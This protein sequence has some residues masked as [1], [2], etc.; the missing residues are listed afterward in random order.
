MCPM[1]RSNVC[2]EVEPSKTLT[3]RLGDLE[4]QV[5]YLNDELDDAEADRSGSEAEAVA[6]LLRARKERDRMAATFRD[7]FSR[8]ET[9]VTTKEEQIDTLQLELDELRK[10]R[11]TE[12]FIA[13]R[14]KQAI[15]RLQEQLVE[16]A[17]LNR[18]C[19]GD[20]SRPQKKVIW[21][22]VLAS[23]EAEMETTASIANLLLAPRNLAARE[24]QTCW[25]RR[26]QRDIIC[27][28]RAWK[29]YKQRTARSDV[30][31]D[32][33]RQRRILDLIMPGH[34][35]P[36]QQEDDDSD[37]DTAED[38]WESA[39]EAE[40]DAA[41]MSERLARAAAWDS[42][43]EPE[44]DAARISERLARVAAWDS[45]WEGESDEETIWINGEWYYIDTPTAQDW[46]VSRVI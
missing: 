41:R 32:A 12:Q 40:S 28:L 17:Y 42:A 20:D 27:H 25:R 44:S 21:G 37:M 11:R 46:L 3:I 39:S 5:G 10:G 29:D 9:L 31:I 13:S 7:N 15:C 19:E 4:D 22:G 8:M 34:C 2:D 24:I 43:W 18:C 23:K 35:Y 6:A 33:A 38:D 14:Q 1:C 30:M 26:H 16:L 45:A 36:Q